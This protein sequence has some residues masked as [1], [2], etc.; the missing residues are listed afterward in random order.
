M[1]LWG[2]TNYISK[3]TSKV[4]IKHVCHFVEKN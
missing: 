1:V 2:G 3:N 4:A